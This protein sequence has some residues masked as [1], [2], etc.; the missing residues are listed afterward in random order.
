M[1]D[2]GWKETDS[3]QDWDVF[4][5]DVHWVHENFDRVYLQ[6]YQKINHFR[7]HYEVS[8]TAVPVVLKWSNREEWSIRAQS[9]H[10][11]CIL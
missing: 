11:C 1:K 5:A 2:R 6:E 3:E 9:S 8:T 10:D 7:N 4:W